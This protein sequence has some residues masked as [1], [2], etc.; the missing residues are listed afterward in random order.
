[1][2]PIDVLFLCETNGATSL[3]A[4]A[5]VNHRAD[6]GWRA[7]SAGLDPAGAAVPEALAALAARGIPAEGLQPKAWTVFAFPGAPRP[8]LVIDLA[9]VSWTRP[10][11]AD[12]GAPV[13]R[14]PMRDPS[15]AEDPAERAAIVEE[16]VAQLTLRLA[17]DLYPRARLAPA[18]AHGT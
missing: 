9:A 13:A 18:A 10:E 7:F 2:K 6:P 12:L 1:M 17:R 11:I 4:E 5:L 8:D 3:I 15:T 16:V 14:W